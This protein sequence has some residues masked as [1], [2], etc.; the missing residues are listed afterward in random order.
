MTA[1]AP[2]AGAGFYLPVSV[3]VP[4]R[5]G[6]TG[7]GM[8]SAPWS[9]PGPSAERSIAG[10]GR[11]VGT[12]RDR[13]LSVQLMDVRRANL[14]ADSCAEGRQRLARQYPTEHCI[15]TRPTIA[16]TGGT[17]FIGRY[18]LRTLSTSGYRVRVLLRRPT[19]LPSGSASA[20]ALGELG[21]AAMKRCET[22]SPGPSEH[23]CSA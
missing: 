19:M 11:S 13:W 5:S 14:E 23:G 22:G 6:G 10:S 17:G 15:V 8:D 21:A 1:F 2:G 4:R 7:R 20:T 3:A 16:L 9:A 18:L 12:S